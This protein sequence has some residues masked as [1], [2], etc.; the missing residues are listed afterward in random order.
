MRLSDLQ[1]FSER[2]IIASVFL[3]VGKH[4]L[5]YIA[6]RNIEGPYCFDEQAAA[7]GTAEDATSREKITI[8]VT[9]EEPLDVA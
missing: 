4:K 8:V 7:S 6:K 1:T 3:N 9:Q 5:S 2:L